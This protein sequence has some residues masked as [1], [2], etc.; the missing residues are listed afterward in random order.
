MGEENAEIIKL[1]TSMVRIYV[2][3]SQGHT[4]MRES[5]S[6]VTLTEAALSHVSWGVGSPEAVQ[7]NETVSPADSCCVVGVAITTGTTRPNR[8]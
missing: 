6:D 5:D 2:N 1:L 8:T 3:T 7:S 4:S